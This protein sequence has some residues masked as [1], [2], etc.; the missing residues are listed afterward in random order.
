MK[1]TNIIISASILLA[2]GL[3]GCSESVSSPTPTVSSNGSAPATPFGPP[4][5]D[6]ASTILATPE[7]TAPTP[8]SKA[9]QAT[10]KAIADKAKIEELTTLAKEAEERL[11]KAPADS[12]DA[13]RAAEEAQALKQSVE[14][15]KAAAEKSAL[16]AAKTK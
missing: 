9:E 12:D 14:T 6:P 2:F 15:A 4:Q 13:A 8:P 11:A 3:T 7:A 16:E 5:S 10:A 1:K